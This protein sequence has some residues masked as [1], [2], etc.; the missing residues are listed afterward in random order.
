MTARRRPS[1]GRIARAL[2]VVVDASVA[3]QWF[4][5]EAGS[6]TAARLIEGEEALAAPDIMPVEAANAWWKKV[7]RRE[8]TPTELQEALV[9]LMALEVHWVPAA[10]LLARAAQL[11]VDIDH[12]VYDCLYLVLAASRQARL[13]TVDER[14]RGA[15]VGLGVRLWVP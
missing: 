3:V 14:L 5:N 12:P 15:A 10:R 4:A 13:A 6:E 1:G 8:M 9:N 11:A 2:P 7:R